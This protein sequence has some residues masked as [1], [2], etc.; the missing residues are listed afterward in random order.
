MFLNIGPSPGIVALRDD[1]PSLVVRAAV[2]LLVLSCPLS[3]VAEYA[4]PITLAEAEESAV[5]AEPGTLGLLS[6][7]SAMQEY[8]VVAQQLPEPVLRLGLNN[9]PIESGGF[10][11]E[12]MTSVGI[13]IR[14]EFPSGSSR[15]ASAR[16]YDSMA[17]GLRDNAGAR[18][19]RVLL[20]VR[21]A[22]LD[23]YQYQEMHKLIAES[24]PLF[25]DLASVSQSLYSVG[26]KS[27]KDV[28]RAE[29]E[30][31]RLDDRALEIERQNNHARAVMSEWIGPQSGR[32][33]ATTLPSSDGLPSLDELQRRLRQHPLLQAADKTIAAKD[34][35]VEIA[36]ERG[37]PRIALDVGYSY[38]EGFLASGGP[39]S[40]FV[41]VAVSV[42]LP[43]FRRQSVDSALTAALGERSAAQSDRERLLRSLRSEL[44][45][46]YMR[47]TDLNR[48]VSLYETKI[49]AQSR[50]HADA[51]LIAYQ[52][53][54]G[55]F[56]D[57]MRGYVDDLDVR[58]E[59]LRLKVERAKSYVLLVNL[60]GLQR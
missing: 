27:Q 46:A 31:S 17:A 7:A 48:R 33:I 34:A 11:T 16:Y 2:T 26:R 5:T 14:Q 4:A 49:L 8:A 15:E 12:G 43:M 41:S 22:W 42:G 30:L 35:G 18:K 40:D 53:D 39:R 13:G 6:K 38:R 60:G 28:L 59:L 36:G 24:R 50:D 29:L 51:A 3:A 9:F 23:S 45:S 55:D 47:W 56:A 32:P 52:N 20:A 37:K 10:D 57:V 58:T 25:V 21:S 44:A 54:K 1:H 19:D